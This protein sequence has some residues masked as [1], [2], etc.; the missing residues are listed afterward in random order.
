MAPI[1]DHWV[2][3][4]EAYMSD[5]LFSSS[6]VMNDGIAFPFRARA[7][8]CSLVVGKRVDRLVPVLP[9]PFVLQRQ[10]TRVRR[11]ALSTG[12]ESP[13]GEEE[14]ELSIVRWYY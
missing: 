3:T 1:P 2:I 8:V 7:S 10:A 6:E 11:S 9:L 12:T 14:N 4:S 5:L 13:T